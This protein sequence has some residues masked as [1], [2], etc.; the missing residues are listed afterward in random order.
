VTLP[1]LLSTF[2]LGIAV[3]ASTNV[4]DILLLSVLFADDHL[5]PR[6]VVLGQFLGIAALVLASGL[7]VLASLAIPRGWIGL[8]GLVPLLLG[9]HKLRASQQRRSDSDERALQEKEKEAENRIHS[10]VL[11]V[12]FVMIVNGADN[13]GVYIPV[14]AKQPSAIPIYAV[15]FAVM[16][17]AWCAIGYFVVNNPVIGRHVRRY[18]RLALPWVLMALGVYILADARVLFASP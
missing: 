2:A 15:L 16:T 7:A 9:M 10:Q 8:L 14:F 6:A 3:F 17:G 4:D 1:T 13:L 12:A 5:R 11:S 18:G